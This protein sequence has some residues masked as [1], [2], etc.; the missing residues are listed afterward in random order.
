[1]KFP[2][3][4]SVVAMCLGTFAAAPEPVAR[5]Q[6]RAVTLLPCSV[7]AETI[8]RTWPGKQREASRVKRA[9]FVN[10]AAPE[11]AATLQIRNL[12]GDF[13]RIRPLSRAAAVTWKDGVLETTLEKPEQFVIEGTRSEIHVF[14]N[15]PF[16]YRHVPGELYFGP[17]EHEAGLIS[18]TNGQTVCFDEG[19]YVYGSILMEGV[20]DVKIV[21]RG[22]LDSSRMIRRQ[23]DDEVLAN[24]RLIA[25][26]RA[27]WNV[28][29]AAFTVM[30]CTNLLVEGVTFVDSPFWAVTVRDECK[31]VLFDNVKLVGQWRYSADG[32][33]ICASE[34]VTI[35]RSFVRSFDDCVVS[36]G[37]ISRRSPA[38]VRHVLVEDCALWCDWGK[39]LEVW[40][41]DKPALIEDV[42]YR[43][44]RLLNVTG[45]ACDVTTWG[46]SA[47][48]V[49]RNIVM[50]DIEVDFPE[51]VTPLRFQTRDNEPWDGLTSRTGSVLR[52]DCRLPKGDALEKVRLDYSDIRFSRF[53]FLGDGVTTRDVYVM[54]PQPPYFNIR[55]VT[56]Y[57]E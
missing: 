33:D 54:P 30:S 43:R 1:M 35:R 53:T 57:E 20:S 15:P 50:E 2:F 48:T 24:E 13:K 27:P 8:N 16:S 55:N 49:F 21:G 26:G 19:A 22:V 41:G 47:S 18:P 42:T 4:I 46:C 29:S 44:C 25:A 37:M 14:V 9:W 56:L 31:G 45:D 23:S 32:F 11:K 36:R 38:V 51:P 3:V 10:L 17:G 28:D 39:N 5:Y 6:E 34:D 12:P 52:V 7:S 40:A